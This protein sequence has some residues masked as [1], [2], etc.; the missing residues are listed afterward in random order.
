M[1]VLFQNTLC[2]EAS[3]LYDNFDIFTREN[4]H[5]MCH[6]G[7]LQKLR[8]GGNG[9][10]ALISWQSIP[11]RF[12][13]QIIDKLGADPIDLIKQDRLEEQMK[14]DP[15]AARFFSEFK[16]PDGRNLPAD[17]QIQYTNDAQ[18]LS[19]IGQIV[20][21]SQRQKKALGGTSAGI[22]KNIAKQVNSI[23]QRSCPHTLPTNHRRI[24][25]KYK[26]F[27]EESYGSLVSKKFCNINSR[28]VTDQI[29]LLLLSLYCLPN[30]PYN[31]NVHDLY[32]QFLGGAI[33]VV[34]VKTGEIFD[35][36]DF[37]KDG[38]PIVITE[39]TVWNYIN[40]PKNRI[41]VDK[42][43]SGK[44]EFSS[45]HR[46]HHH[47]DMPQFS[48]SKISMDD[49]DLP[50]KMHD[51]KRVKTYYSYDIASGCILGA[52]YSK[53]KDTDL[54][55]DCMRDMFRFLYLNNIGIPMEVEVENHLVSQFEHTLMKAGT[56]FPFVRW[57][58][59]G[60]A[61][62]KWAETGHRV[63]KYGYEKKYQDGIGRF[64]SKL[65]ANRTNQEKIFDEENNR[66]K[67]TTYDYDQLVAEDRALIEMYNND[68]HPNQDK[69]PKMTRLQVMLE[70]LNPNMAAY[71]EYLLSRYIGVAVN[72]T[73][74]RSQYVQ[75][76]YTKYQLP[77]VDIMSRLKPN[78]RSVTA[79]Y[80]PTK[81]S[82]PETI[83]LYQGDEFICACSEIVKYNTARA[84][85]TDKDQEAYT[86]QA[87]YVA[88]F[89]KTVKSEKIHKVTV[90][91]NTA[92]LDPVNEVEI[93]HAQ[94]SPE[95]DFDFD[96]E[97]EKS[98]KRN[99]VDSL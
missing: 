50:R 42:Y 32:M 71:Q 49:R 18:L 3:A 52:A 80:I 36:K 17:V 53:K 46:P 69:Y 78:N 79:Y 65:E 22:W 12:K 43:R 28:K 55:I 21:R 73:I 27:I 90:I 16:L 62:E 95:D 60:N 63:K 14:Y 56:V 2:L 84:E 94:E 23:D 91:Q 51:G 29:K 75:V 86:E 10:T 8:T 31:K 82:K 72:T 81:D 37:M 38:E 26:L 76:S 20:H 24:Q 40:D 47:R 68:P 30:K 88:S 54:F 98:I 58:N 11:E 39:A 45:T 59:P 9:R 4:Y 96:F 48:L 1:V 61:Q 89:D 66:W 6:R 44:L 13:K 77:D 5:K 57:A 25:A 41:L 83:Y 70:N 97:T 64:F 34:D 15:A 92:S 33:E 67:E 87:K 35:R 85:W 74:R 93:V 19:T 7:K 99:A